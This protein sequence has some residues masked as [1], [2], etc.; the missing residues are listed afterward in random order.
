L[1][2]GDFRKKCSNFDL[3]CYERWVCVCPGSD[4]LG[5]RGFV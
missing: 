5:C 2:A 4:W 3:I 1:K